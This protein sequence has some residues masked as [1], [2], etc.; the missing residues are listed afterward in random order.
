ML[1]A[2]ALAGFFLV[3]M[4]AVF[5]AALLGGSFWVFGKDFF[6]IRADTVPIKMLLSVL[7]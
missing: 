7:M 5:V 3:A 6:A 2:V 1:V 4:A